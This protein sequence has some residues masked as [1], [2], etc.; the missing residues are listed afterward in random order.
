MQ[1]FYWDVSLV[2]RLDELRHDALRL[3]IFRTYNSA[4][5]LY[6]KALCR[7]ITVLNIY[8]VEFQPPYLADDWVLMLQWANLGHRDFET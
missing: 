6:T 4:A 3:H 7:M 2:N 1:Y 5:L 8:D